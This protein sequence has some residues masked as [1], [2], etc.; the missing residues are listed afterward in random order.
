MLNKN[1]YIHLSKEKTGICFKIV[2]EYWKGCFQKKT[3]RQHPGRLGGAEKSAHLCQPLS[4]L[5]QGGS[6]VELR[7]HRAQPQL[8]D[9][10]LHK[11]NGSVRHHLPSAI[12]SYQAASQDHVQGDLSKPEFNGSP[13]WSPL[14]INPRER[15]C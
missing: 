13:A 1:D 11:A 6:V 12:R 7:G 10:T 3:F 14:P 8:S 9:G 4:E 15:V 5:L 2:H